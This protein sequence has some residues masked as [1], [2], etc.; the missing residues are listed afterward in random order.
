MVKRSILIG[1]LSEWSTV[2]YTDC[3]VHKLAKK[4]LNNVFPN[5]P[6]TSS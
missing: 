1:S 4:E 3:K 2:C 6:H 5:E